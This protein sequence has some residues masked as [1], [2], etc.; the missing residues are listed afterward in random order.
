MRSNA[1]IQPILNIGHHQTTCSDCARDQAFLKSVVRPDYETSGPELRVVDLFAGVGG[2]TLG[3]AE[4]ARRMGMATFVSLAVESDPAT[5]SLYMRNFPTASS[6]CVDITR[7]FDGPLGSNATATE[8]SVEERV[9]KVD[10]LLAGPPCQGHSALNNRTRHDDPRNELYL[11]AI[12]A[13]EVLHPSVI[14]IENV[15]MVRKDRHHVVDRALG[16]LLNQDYMVSESILDLSMYGVPQRRRR[17]IL[18][19]IRNYLVSPTF[20]IGSYTSSIH[21]QRDI[22]WAIEDLL[23]MDIRTS[24][25]VPSKATSTNLARMRWLIDNDEYNL[26]NEM[27]PQCHRD[28]QHKYFSMYG[29][30]RW[31]RPA[32]TI[33]TGFGSMGQGR[34]V[35]PEVART[36]TPH[37]AARLQTIPDFFDLNERSRPGIWAKAIGNAVP[38]MLGVNLIT[39]LLSS[40]SPPALIGADLSLDAL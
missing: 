16:A 18:I 2:L 5:H 15:P 7:L 20:L 11:R 12:R 21:C 30:L 36:I 6:E 4:A 25:D 34:F 38:P 39:S 10:L 23:H 8:R 29:R 3:A 28:K 33:T 17:H 32:Q 22:R 19:G 9:G 35:H 13:A 40:L 24:L 26:P 14:L 31:D 1:K 27:R 37:E